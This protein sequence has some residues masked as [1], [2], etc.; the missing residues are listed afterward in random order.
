MLVVFPTTLLIDAARLMLEQGGRQVVVVLDENG[1]LRPVAM[2][3]DGDLAYH[4]VKAS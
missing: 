4:I 2:L 1:Q 3:T